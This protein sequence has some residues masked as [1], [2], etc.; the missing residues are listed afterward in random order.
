[1]G[2][3]SKS[4]SCRIWNQ[5]SGKNSKKTEN[6]DLHGFEVHWPSSKGTKLLLQVIK[7]IINQFGIRGQMAS[8]LTS[9]TPHASSLWW[10][11]F[12]RFKIWSAYCKCQLHLS[13]VGISLS[14]KTTH[15]CEWACS[16]DDCER[17][18]S[19]SR[20]HLMTISIKAGKGVIFPSSALLHRFSEKAISSI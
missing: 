10:N 19:S 5:S 2:F 16:T 3:G 12:W 14:R 18:K 9:I 11:S 7:A 4:C 6:S 8:W 13:L 17:N 1:M 15:Q 20:V